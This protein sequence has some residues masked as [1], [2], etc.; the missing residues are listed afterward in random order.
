MKWKQNE[1]G[2]WTL[3][4]PAQTTLFIFPSDTGWKF[5]SKRIGQD[6]PTFHE[7]VYLSPEIAMEAIEK[8]IDTNTYTPPPDTFN[9]DEA[10]Q[11]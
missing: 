6:Y 4:T 10:T 5:G 11:L 2:N 3:T 1:K 7:E 8:R 9:Y